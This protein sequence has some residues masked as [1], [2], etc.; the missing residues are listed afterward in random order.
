M[1]LGK[2][3][4]RKFILTALLATPVALA[5]DAKFIEPTWL[6]VR[7]LRLGDGQAGC[8]FAHI[9]DIHHKGDRL[10]LQSVVDTINSLKPDFVCFTGDLIERKQFLPEALE[11]LSGLKSPLF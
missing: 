3:N 2:I 5:G 9:S 10:Y 8:R 4:R 1:K 11:V 6:K 7:R